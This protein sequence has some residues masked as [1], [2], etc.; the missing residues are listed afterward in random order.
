MARKRLPK[1]VPEIGEKW[2]NS[3]LVTY[4]VSYRYNGGIVV[5]G[6]WHEGY[7]VPR[8]HVPKGYMLTGI[9]CGFQMNA[10]PP[11]ATC[12]IVRKDGSDVTKT[13]LKSDLDALR[14]G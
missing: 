1:P 12:M 13:Q 5:N 3:Y 10:R 9:G 7:L 11:Q 6:K 2:C 4:P 14:K 8:P